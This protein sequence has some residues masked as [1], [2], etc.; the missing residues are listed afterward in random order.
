MKNAIV[1]IIGVLMALHLNA[2]KYFTRTGMTQF[3]ASEEAFEP[4]EAVNKSTTAIFNANTR[5]VVAQV[6]MAAFQFDNALMQEHFN[7]N[8]MDSHQYPKAIFKGILEDFSKNKLTSDSS[9]F[10]LDGILTIKGIEKEIHTKVYL[11]EENN[12]LYVT[13]NFWVKPEDFDISI[14]S[15]VR[16]KIAEQIQISIAYELIERK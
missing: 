14:P 1:I 16:N 8:Y 9:S 2:Q 6:F 15:I 11:K 12:R 7:E 10:D 4:V 5:Q 3:K 13:T